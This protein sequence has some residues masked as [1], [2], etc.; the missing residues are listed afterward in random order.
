MGDE[1]EILPSPRTP[2]YG[3]RYIR[4][5]APRFALPS[6]GANT[7]GEAGNFSK[8][9]SLCEESSEFFQVH[10]PLID[11][12]VYFNDDPQLASLF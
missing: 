4:R 1:L 3:G 11:R 10:G 2:I 6:P 7:G 12:K 5:L 9:Q 8:Y